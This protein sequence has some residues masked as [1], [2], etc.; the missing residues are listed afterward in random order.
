MAFYLAIALLSL[1]SQ[2][3]VTGA[4][5][6][7]RL[8]E[9]SGLIQQ[10]KEINVRC[11]LLPPIRQCNVTRGTSQTY[12]SIA[13]ISAEHKGLVAWAAG[14]NGYQGVQQTSPAARAQF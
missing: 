11:S 13:S 5:H 4:G 6:R 7:L 9:D 1:L 8:V 3:V 12:G 2:R 10:A 14:A